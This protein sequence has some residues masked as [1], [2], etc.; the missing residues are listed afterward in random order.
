MPQKKTSLLALALLLLAVC[1][2]PSAVA[3][4]APA[5]QRLY[6]PAKGGPLEVGDAPAAIA[7]MDTEGEFDD[8]IVALSGENRLRAIVNVK[9]KLSLGPGSAVGFP[10]LSLA[11]SEAASTLAIGPTGSAAL[12]DLRRWSAAGPVLGPARRAAVGTRPSG[13]IASPVSI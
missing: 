5:G 1:A 13:V 9:G 8:L 7:V 11:V 12:L 6:A 10:P 4:T 2:W 3:A